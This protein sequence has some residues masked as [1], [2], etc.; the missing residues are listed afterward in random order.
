[1]HRH[2]LDHHTIEDGTIYDENGEEVDGS[3]TPV[4]A[5]EHPANLDSLADMTAAALSVVGIT[6]RDIR[7]SG[8]CELQVGTDMFIRLTRRI[9]KER[10]I[11]GVRPVASYGFQVGHFERKFSH[12]SGE[13]VEE[14]IDADA[15]TPFEAAKAAA[16]A[17]VELRLDHELQQSHSPESEADLGILTG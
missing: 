12:S 4:S 13:Y 10:G 16:L 7:P 6:D 9:D 8:D 5:E 11:G 2:R 14:H 1:M 15:D 3:P 17:L